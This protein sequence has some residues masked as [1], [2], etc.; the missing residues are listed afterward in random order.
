MANRHNSKLRCI[1]H[2]PR[3][4]ILFIITYLVEN[5]L[6]MGV[7]SRA[8]AEFYSF[9][10]AASLAWAAL[11]LRTVKFRETRMKFFRVQN[12]PFAPSAQDNPFR[13]AFALAFSPEDAG[14][15][16]SPFRWFS[17]FRA[18]R[19]FRSGDMMFSFIYKK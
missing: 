9:D 8:N 12:M 1:I 18:K 7:F 2:P 6:V 19:R 11:N 16:A 10:L 4:T 17:C 13:L 15:V 5:V 3:Q 14:R